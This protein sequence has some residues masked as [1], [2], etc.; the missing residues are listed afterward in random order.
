MATNTT[1]TTREIKREEWPD[2]FDGFSRRHEG[3]LVTIELLDKEL[4]DQIE[5]ENKALKGIVAERKRDPQV[6]DIFVWNKP[7]EDSSHMIDK[8]TRVL[9][10]ETPE[11]AEVALE[12]ESEDHAT[13]LLTFKSAA[14]PETVDG[15]APER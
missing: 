6:I 11:G 4:G 1:M 15:V 7:E 13:T 2:F 8:P 10:E 14:L 9:V 12:I 3:W 5:V